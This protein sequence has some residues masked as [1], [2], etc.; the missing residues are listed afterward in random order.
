MRVTKILGLVR[1][2][3]TSPRMRAVLLLQL[4]GECPAKKDIANQIKMDCNYS[5][6]FF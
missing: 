5:K 3:T 4:G 6:R 1:N 2:F